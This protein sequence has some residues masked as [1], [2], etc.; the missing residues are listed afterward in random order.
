MSRRVYNKTPVL[1][2]EPAIEASEISSAAMV[3]SSSP[4]SLSPAGDV[5]L[6]ILENDAPATQLPPA[7]ST[8]SQT[9]NVIKKPVE[10]ASS[11]QSPARALVN[12]MLMELP[13]TNAVSTYSLSPSV[14]PPD[15]LWFRVFQPPVMPNI[16]YYRT[17][18]PN[19]FVS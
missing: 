16:P 11:Y 14:S 18:L 7:P 6:A 17:L 10:F 19:T 3:T 1:T 8:V 15:P 4:S 12:P 2:L 9:T 13:N 5:P